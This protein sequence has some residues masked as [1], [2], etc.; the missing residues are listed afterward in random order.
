M[1]KH[2]NPD[3]T[4]WVTRAEFKALSLKQRRAL[5]AERAAVKRRNQA[6]HFNVATLRQQLGWQSVMTVLLGAA[7]LGVVGGAALNW[8]N[9]VRA[10]A[11]EPAPPRVEQKIETITPPVIRDQSDIEWERRAQ[12][13]GSAT[14]SP[15]SG[16]AR[17]DGVRVAFGSCKW[18][19]GKNCVVDGDT[20][21]LNGAKVRIAGIDAPETHDY[22]C[23]SELELGERAARQ[24]SLAVKMSTRRS[25]R[26]QRNAGVSAPSDLSF[27][28]SS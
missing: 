1:S 20:F 27:S 25:R 19:G 24:L 11:A 7:F 2:W 6:V 22:H 12:D 4:P 3:G 26:A 10:P 23:T 21:Y 18:G 15:P 28:L 13:G 17:N 8:R 14:G 9:P 5:Y 16:G